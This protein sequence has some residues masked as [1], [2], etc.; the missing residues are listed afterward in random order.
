MSDF[1][2]TDI[3]SIK[4]IIPAYLYDQYSDDDDLQAMFDAYNQMAQAYLDWFNTTPLA[5]YTNDNITGALL[6]WLANGIYGQERPAL[7]NGGTRNVGPFNTYGFNDTPYD[8]FDI[9]GPQTLFVTTDDVFKRII[10]WNFFKG[11]GF[12]FDVLWLKRR[13]MRFLSGTNG[14]NPPIDNTYQVSV[15]FGVDNAIT[16]RLLNGIRT[17][18]SGALFNTNAFNTSMFDELDTSF[19]QFTPL[20]FAAIFKAAV[21]AGVLNLPFQYTYTVVID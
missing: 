19:Q 16:I 4:K 14:T 8:A 17:P 7:P 15:T 2:P 20:A 6:D 9:I 1:P 11:D 18:I 21:D 10:T 13:V 12:Y 3:T 5:I